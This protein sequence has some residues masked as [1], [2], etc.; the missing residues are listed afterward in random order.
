MTKKPRGSVLTALKTTPPSSSRN[1][2]WDKLTPAQLEEWNA[3]CEAMKNGELDH[4][5]LVD[6]KRIVCSSF[7]FKVCMSTFRRQLG[8]AGM[9]KYR[10]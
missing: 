3:I 2:P 6:I 7:D 8:E 9:I 1:R 10:S 5:S 4:L